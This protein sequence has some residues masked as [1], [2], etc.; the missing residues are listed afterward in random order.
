MSTATNIHR[1]KLG[2]TVKW[3]DSD[4]EYVSVKLEDDEGNDITAFMDV[5]D[6]HTFVA[7]LKLAQAREPVCKVGPR[8]EVATLFDPADVSP[9]FPPA[10]GETSA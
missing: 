5:A 8:K 1:A 3:R 2:K 4:R 9:S 7:Q 6:F 10:P